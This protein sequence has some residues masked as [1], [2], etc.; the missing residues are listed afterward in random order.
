MD[1]A[2]ITR[3]MKEHVGGKSFINIAELC[4]YIGCGKATARKILAD[5]PFLPSGRE[6]RYL[7]KDVAKEL[8]LRSTYE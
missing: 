5:V 7:I 6:K 3:D 2:G 4:A 8:K 1:I